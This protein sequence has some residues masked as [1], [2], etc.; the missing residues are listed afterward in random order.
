MYNNKTVKKNRIPYKCPGKWFRKGISLVEVMDMFPDDHTAGQW[1]ANV[2][3]PDEPG[4]NRIE[5][6]PTCSRQDG[7]KP[8]VPESDK[9]ELH[10]PAVQAIRPSG[11]AAML[12]HA[13]LADS[14]LREPDPACAALRSGYPP[15]RPARPAASSTSCR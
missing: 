1:F 6:R 9:P 3:W 5:S 8:P 12:R 4:R 11:S 13:A 15:P 7:S 2:R 14:K 10:A